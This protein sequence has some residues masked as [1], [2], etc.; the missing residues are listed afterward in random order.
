MKIVSIIL[1]RGGS[2]GI[3]NKNIISINNKPLISYVIEAS[4]D[5]LVNETWVST[6]DKKIA[7]ISK[8]YGANVLIRPKELATDISQSEDALIH[9]AEE[10]EFDVLVFIQPTSPLLKPQDINKGLEIFNTSD[11]VFSAYKEHWVGRWN[12]SNSDR[13]KP[14]HW[15]INNRPRRQDV[16]EVYVENGA[17]YI[18]SKKRLLESKYRYSG[19][20]GCYEMP[21]YRSFQIDTYEDLEFINK[22]I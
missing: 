16:E 19:K 8:K 6:D 4:K 22:I 17:F 15:N 1:A 5:S 14:L 20:I 12:K 11:S 2:K 7:D 3:K 18:T 9:F 21:F 13:C 10:V